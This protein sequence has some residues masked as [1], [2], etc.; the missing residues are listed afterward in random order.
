MFIENVIHVN[1]KK[2]AKTECNIPS[3]SNVMKEEV[4]IFS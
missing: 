2:V 3:L 4:E 1:K